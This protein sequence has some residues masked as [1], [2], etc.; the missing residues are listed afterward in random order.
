MHPA[1]VSCPACDTLGSYNQGFTDGGN[2]VDITSD[3]EAVCL[4]ASGLYDAGTNS[5]SVDFEGICLFYE[6][7]GGLAS[8]SAACTQVGGT[9]DAGTSTCTPAYNC[10]IGGF[11]SQAAIDFPPV[12]YGYTNVYDGHTH[13][14]E[15]ALG[16]G[17]LEGSND[18]STPWDHGKRYASPVGPWFFNSTPIIQLAVGL[19]Q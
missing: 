1:S 5:C 3:N 19:C 7:T 15:P 12:A 11:C 18:I 14:T 6:P 10:F 9:W 8:A 17:C 2:G 4:T 16:A 13:T